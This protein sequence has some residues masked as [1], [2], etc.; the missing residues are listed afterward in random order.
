MSDLLCFKCG[1]FE[2]LSGLSL[3]EKCYIETRNVNLTRGLKNK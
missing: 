3:C 2:R 1:K